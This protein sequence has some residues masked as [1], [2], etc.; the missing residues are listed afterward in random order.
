VCRLRSL[1]YSLDLAIPSWSDPRALSVRTSRPLTLTA[2]TYIYSGIC[3]C[4]DRYS[5]SLLCTSMEMC[6]VAARGEGLPCEYGE[7]YR[8]EKRNHLDLC[9]WEVVADGIIP[10]NKEEW[11]K[12]WLRK[13]DRNSTRKESLTD[14]LHD[15]RNE[16]SLENGKGRFQTR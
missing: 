3:E 4:V 10:A 8:F 7:N 9:V 15:I 12:K 16:E 1:R 2:K 13:R 6:A 5:L 11:L 14:Q